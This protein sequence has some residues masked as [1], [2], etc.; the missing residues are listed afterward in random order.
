MAESHRRDD[1]IDDERESRPRAQAEDGACSRPSSLP[2]A[3]IAASL[4]TLSACDPGL[5]IETR[6]SRCQDQLSRDL[7]IQRRRRRHRP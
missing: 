4:T 1:A 2:S 7:T 3:C 6:P 5:K